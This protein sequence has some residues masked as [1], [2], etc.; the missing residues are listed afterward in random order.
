MPLKE[1]GSVLRYYRPMVLIKVKGDSQF[2]FK[3]VSCDLRH[4][5]LLDALATI[6]INLHIVGLAPYGSDDVTLALKD[7]VNEFLMDWSNHL[8][9]GIGV[10]DPLLVN[11]VLLN[12]QATTDTR[13]LMRDTVDNDNLHT[14]FLAFVDSIDVSLWM[15]W[16]SQTQDIVVSQLRIEVGRAVLRVNDR[17]LVPRTCK[18]PCDKQC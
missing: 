10:L 4:T 1:I 16:C 11:L 2:V 12:L 13:P 6:V 17:N 7:S 5:D 8:P 3:T 15:I 14:G 9:S 18:T